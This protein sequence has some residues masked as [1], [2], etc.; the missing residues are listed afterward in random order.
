MGEA[1][2]MPKKVLLVD[3][4]ENILRLLEMSV[5]GSYKPIL[6]RNGI[7]AVKRAKE[8]NPDTIVLDLMMPGMDGFEVIKELKKLK[9]TKDIP[10]IVLSALHSREVRERVMNEGVCDY[11]I[12]PFAP[13]DLRFKLQ[14]F[15]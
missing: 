11:M 14:L 5:Q 3:D 15:S 13:D 12:K 1:Q 8:D 2:H 7:E 4:E 10:I 9:E 6:A